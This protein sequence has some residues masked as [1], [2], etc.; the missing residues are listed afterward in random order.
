MDEGIDYG[1]FERGRHLNYW[2][3]DPTLQRELQRV[4]DAD[5]F[6]WAEPRL[7]E[8]GELI[9]YTVADNADYV[10]DH[11]PELLTYDRFGE[12][13]N[14][15]RYPAEQIE[16]ERAVYEAGIV[17]DAFEAPPG[18]E[19]RLPISH[20]LGMLHLLSYAEGGGFGCPVAMTA[21]AALVL[22]KFD[23]GT[24]EPYYDA[25]VSREYDKLI[26]GAMFLT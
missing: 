25:L 21:G 3:H 12:V 26:E 6:E 11:G 22:E 15:V 9:G 4:Y 8:F 5:G 18:R 13:Q 2:S 7:A 24:L 17:A 23:D 1:Q 14:Y 19:E 20:Y 16:N 10:D